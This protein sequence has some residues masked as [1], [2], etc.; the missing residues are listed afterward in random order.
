MDV[1]EAILQM[2]L[3]GHDFF[4]FLN[5]KTDTISVVYNGNTGNTASS[6]RNTKVSRPLT[7]D[8]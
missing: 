2:N 5:S 3:V 8:K 7:E 1:E 4:V 6:N